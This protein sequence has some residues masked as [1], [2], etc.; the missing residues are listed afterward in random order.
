VPPDGAEHGPKSSGKQGVGNPS[1]A[2]CGALGA[3]EAPIDPELVAV[4]DAW[5]KLPQAIRAGILAMIR[6]AGDGARADR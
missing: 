6:A 5:P 2:E 3:R 1:G 4:V